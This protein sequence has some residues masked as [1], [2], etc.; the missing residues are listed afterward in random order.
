MKNHAKR[1]P[2]QQVMLYAVFLFIFQLVSRIENI[3]YLRRGEIH[4][5]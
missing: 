2:R 1:F 3:V 4:K 5:F